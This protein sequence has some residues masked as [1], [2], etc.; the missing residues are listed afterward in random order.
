MWSPSSTLARPT[1]NKNDATNGLEVCSGCPMIPA[2]AISS[3]VMP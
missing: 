3:A 2:R 1:S